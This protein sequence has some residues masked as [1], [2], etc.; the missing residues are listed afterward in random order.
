MEN[1]LEDFVRLCLA[2]NIEID[3][4][5]LNSNVIEFN[6]TMNDI[7]GACDEL[8]ISRFIFYKLIQ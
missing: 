3:E 7:L 5:S 1:I 2:S 8:L 6:T 4:Y